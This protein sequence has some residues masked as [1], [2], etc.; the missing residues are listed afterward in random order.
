KV[1]A[2]TRSGKVLRVKG[3]GGPFKGRG[4]L[5]PD[6]RSDVR[7][8]GS[9]G[10]T[11]DLLVMIEVQVPSKLTKKEKE[12]LEQFAALQKEDPRAH[13]AEFIR[14]SEAASSMEA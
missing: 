6:G 1:P 10:K 5:S 14:R 12:L 4:S 9:G 2:G 7:V 13:F 3:R 8:E 11:G